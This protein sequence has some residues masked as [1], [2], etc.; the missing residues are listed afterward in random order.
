MSAPV[1]RCPNC[2][3]TQRAAGE[4]EACHEAQVRWYCP[5]HT[6]GL[7]LD[8][9]VCPECGARAG[10]ERRERA[11]REGAERER[12]E[13]ER[14]ER[15]RAERQRAL[16]AERERDAVERR[17]RERAAR[18]TPVSWKTPRRVPP[19]APSAP[20]ARVARR[21]PWME[22]GDV[23][24]ARDAPDGSDGL[25]PW[26][27]LE[28]PRLPVARIAGCVGRLA[29]LALVLGVLLA[30]GTCWLLGGGG[31]GSGSGAGGWVVDAGQAVGVVDGVPAQTERGIAAYRAGDIATAERE[32]SE[33]AAAYRRSSLA[34]VYLARIRLDAGD[35]Y[36]AGEYLREAVR[37]EPESVLAQR[38]LGGFHLARADRAVAAGASGDAAAVGDDLRIAEEHFA[39]AMT[40]DPGDREA[41]G[42][43]ACAL[44]RLGRREEALA[45]LAVAGADGAW[46]AC[47][48]NG[49]RD[50]SSAPKR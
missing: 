48:L 12:A 31:G 9:A 49:A 22:R 8:S 42:Y 17:A 4:C 21:A 27:A 1:L 44:G 10:Q 23:P 28:V 25:P 5:N 16:D 11:V 41:R 26:T 36:R 19:S 7:W 37:R 34:L 39:R 40:L 46:A 45:Q 24:A 47:V 32:L 6:P 20:P 43:R 3:T 30:L 15:E 29:M 14:A 38:Q 50:G 13:H 2:G 35:E 18:P 33:A